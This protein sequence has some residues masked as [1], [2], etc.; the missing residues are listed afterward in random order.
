MHI[1]L[2]K[3]V[4]FYFLFKKAYTTGKTFLQQKKNDLEIA[5]YKVANIESSVLPI[6]D[7]LELNMFLKSISLLSLVLYLK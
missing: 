1:P 2:I 7:N 4:G 6:N 3:G 5:G